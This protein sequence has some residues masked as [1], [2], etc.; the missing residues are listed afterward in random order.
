MIGKH[1]IL[2]LAAEDLSMSEL[3]QFLVSGL[4]V[5]LITLMVLALF[6]TVMGLVFKSGAKPRSRTKLVTTP[7]QQL[8]PSS[9]QPEDHTTI[10]I[11]AAVASAIDQPHRIVHVG[12]VADDAWALERRFQHH[13]SHKVRRD[14]R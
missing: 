4:L 12:S 7:P 14:A 8:R 6:C 3:L 11:A 10:V 5:V 2:L 9:E 1:A 13:H